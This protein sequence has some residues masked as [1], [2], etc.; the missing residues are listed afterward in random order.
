MVKGASSAEK[1]YQKI[2]NVPRTQHDASARDRER[3]TVY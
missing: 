1:E 3:A 2:K